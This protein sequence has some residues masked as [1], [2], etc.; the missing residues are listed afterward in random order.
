MYPIGNVED[1]QKLNKLV[2]L[3]NE[4][5][6]VRLQDKLGKQ[7]FHGDMKKVLETV[8]KYNKDVS[9]NVTKTITETSNK[10]NK[11]LEKINIKLLEIMDDRGLLA[12]YL[13]SPLYKITNPEISTHFKIVKGSSS[14]RV[15]D[16]LI[17]N[18]TP[19]N[20]YNN[21]LTFLD[22]VKAF[23]LQRDLLKMI[24]NKYYNVHL[25]NLWDKKLMYDFA[26][27]M[28]F[29]L[30]AE[31]RKST[32]DSTFIKLLKSPGLMVSA[33]GVSKAI[34]LSSDIIEL[35]DRIK[36]LLQE[37]Q[38]GNISDLN[39]YEIVAIVDKLLEYKCISKKQHNQLLFK[40]NVY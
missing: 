38:A 7:N 39:N 28:I 2:S 5:K 32:R 37:K 22:T 25:A 3:E 35:C 8:T 10:N 23:E 33:S 1:L 16:L 36:L 13:M 17:N 15:N 40:C 9:E 6:S 14:N 19:N 34:T 24:N 21:L 12:S 27:E 29:D 4:V 20:L 31:S 18:T 26:K 30:I 11:A